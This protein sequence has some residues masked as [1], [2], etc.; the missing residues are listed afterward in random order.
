MHHHL[1]L[2]Y[3]AEQLEKGMNVQLLMCAQ[4]VD[5]RSDGHACGFFPE[6]RNECPLHLFASSCCALVISVHSCSEITDLVVIAG[7]IEPSRYVG[8]FPYLA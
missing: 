4:V 2:T 3:D 6:D 1:I 7:G 8:V 5:S